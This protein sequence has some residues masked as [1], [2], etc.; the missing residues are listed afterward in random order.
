MSEICCMNKKH[1][2][3][4]RLALF[5]FMYFPCVSDG[6][7]T[8]ATIG[9][10]G[11][12]SLMVKSTLTDSGFITKNDSGFNL[13]LCKLN[14]GIQST[15]T[16]AV[17]D[18]DQ[19]FKSGPYLNPF[20]KLNVGNSIQNVSMSVGDSLTVSTKSSTGI[21]KVMFMKVKDDRTIKVMTQKGSG[22][23]IRIK[24]FILKAPLGNEPKQLKRQSIT[25]SGNGNK[26]KIISLK[27][28][29]DDP[30]N[31]TESSRI[32]NGS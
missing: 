4:Y 29:S 7:N 10:F 19:V 14:S 32:I 9:R 1:L 27:F 30:Q 12:T 2:S 22:D 15:Q 3:A 20:V 26:I 21:P 5:C 6:I 24:R 16:L 23:G 11:L 25:Y 17:L 18:S 31:I 13:K 8:S 28:S